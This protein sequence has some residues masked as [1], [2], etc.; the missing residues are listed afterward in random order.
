M[1]KK[2]PSPRKSGWVGEKETGEVGREQAGEVPFTSGNRLSRHILPCFTDSFRCWFSF[3]LSFLVLISRNFSVA[4]MVLS[5]KR[6]CFAKSAKACPPA[7]SLILLGSV[8]FS[9]LGGGF[10]WQVISAEMWQTK[11]WR[12]AQWVRTS[13]DGL[14]QRTSV[15]MDWLVGPQGGMGLYLAQTRFQGWRVLWSSLVSKLQSRFRFLLLWPK[16]CCWGLLHRVGLSTSRC[17][18]KVG[19]IWLSSC[20]GVQSFR[21]CIPQKSRGCFP[22]STI[23]KENTLPKHC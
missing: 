5:M 10:W 20:V 18:Y 22:L 13:C 9:C 1:P 17:S 14:W 16:A 4:W 19:Y 21:T 2:V 15:L 8:S 23:F 3:Y 7:C 6:R 12:C 11:L